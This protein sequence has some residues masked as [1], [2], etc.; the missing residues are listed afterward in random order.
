[1][2]ELGQMIKKKKHFVT[3]LLELALKYLLCI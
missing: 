2:A 3:L 1:M